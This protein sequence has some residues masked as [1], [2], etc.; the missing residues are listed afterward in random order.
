[1]L[2]KP[3]H[4]KMIKEGTKHVTRRT[5]KRPMVKVG[6]MY[7]AQSYMYQPKKECPRIECTALYQQI[8]GDMDEEDADWEGGYTLTEFKVLWE[9]INK[10]HWNPNEVVWVVAFRLHEGDER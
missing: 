5:W 9:R 6:G 3:E 1:M 8:L 7:A 2:F 10:K 4:I